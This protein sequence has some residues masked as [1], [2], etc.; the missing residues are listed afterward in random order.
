MKPTPKFIALLYFIGIIFCASCSKG[1]H[2]NLNQPV[3]PP[4]IPPPPPQPILVPGVDTTLKG[5]Q[6]IFPSSF[7]YW[8]D[9]GVFDEIYVSINPSDSFSIA[10]LSYLQT[11][12]S[13]QIDTSSNWI[14]LP[15]YNWY[16]NYSPFSSSTGLY[17]TFPIWPYQTNSYFL[18]ESAPL[19]F[20]LVGK[21][22][23]VRIKFI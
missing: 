17:W 9:G 18:I 8:Q 4:V 16:N 1:G 19:N 12:V 3:Q 14:S 13:I 2:N 15:F 21:S 10:S 6:F 20:Q 7:L 5:Q 22:L 11:E 23:K